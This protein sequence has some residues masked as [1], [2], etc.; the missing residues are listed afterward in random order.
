MSKFFGYIFHEKQAT[1][2]KLYFHFRN[3]M[4]R[5]LRPILNSI[6][7]TLQTKKSPCH[8]DDINFFFSFWQNRIKKVWREKFCCFISQLFPPI[9]FASLGRAS[10]YQFVHTQHFKTHKT[11]KRFLLLLKKFFNLSN[12]CTKCKE[13]RNI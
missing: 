7:R 10:I 8:T 2:Q 9:S 5:Y 11:V 13:H 6:W 3:L 1:P 12:V 4:G